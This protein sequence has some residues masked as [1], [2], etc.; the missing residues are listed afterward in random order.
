[1]RDQLVRVLLSGFGRAAAPCEDAAEAIGETWAAEYPCDDDADHASSAS[2][3]V[4]ALHRHFTELG[5]DPE[6]DEES[7]LL[8]LRRCPFGD[9]A[10]QHGD[11]VCGVHVGLARGLLSRHGGPLTVR[12]IGPGTHGCVVA[13]AVRSV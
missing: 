13:L 6:L 3:Q 8:R 7:M 10:R 12:S 2:A 1:V 11:V 5:F 9:L 4:A